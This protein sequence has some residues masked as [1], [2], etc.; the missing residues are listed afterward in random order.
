M[1]GIVQF[2]NLFTSKF[3]LDPIFTQP[4]PAGM[5]LSKLKIFSLSLKR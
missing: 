5:F 4:F 2:N 1:I 3:P